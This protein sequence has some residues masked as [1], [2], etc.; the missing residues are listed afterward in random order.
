MPGTII[1]EY[2][3]D[4]YKENFPFSP[5]SLATAIRESYGTC[6]QRT[7]RHAFLIILLMVFPYR[8]LGGDAARASKR[9]EFTTQAG[10]AKAWL[11]R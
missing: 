1:A 2:R 7:Q 4:E 11:A 10:A 5:G 9:E 8:G 6:T 3:I